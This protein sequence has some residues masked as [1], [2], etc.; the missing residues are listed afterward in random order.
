[1]DVSASHLPGEL[2]SNCMD[3]AS[4]DADGDGDLDLVLAVEYERNALLLNDGDGMFIDA[5]ERLPDAALD[6]EDVEFTDVDADGDLDLVIVSERGGANELYLNDGTGRFSDA[7]ERLPVQGTSNGLAVLDLD[8]DSSPDLLIG[9]YGAQGVMINTGEGRFT[10]GTARHWPG[11]EGQTQD[12][13]L[14]DVDGDGD[15]DVVV[16]NEGQNQ[17]FINDAG[18]LVDETGSRLPER[19]DETREIRSGDMDGDGDLDLVVANVQLD[20][21]WP[22]QDWLLLNDGSGHFSDA[23]PGRFPD[24]SRD[25]FTIQAADLDGDGDLDIIGPAS[26]FTGDSLDHRVLLNDGSGTFTV[27]REGEILPSS[28]HGKGLGFDIEVGDFDGDGRNDL[29]FCDRG[30]SSNPRGGVVMRGRPS[31]VLNRPN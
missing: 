26:L 5:S 25:H 4:G 6:S 17:L 30:S 24:G 2:P 18:R 1:M 12:L 16:G 22:R 29:F 10:D 15:L 21:E 28:V 14:A 3:A 11:A 9:N 19:E 20:Y 31:L 8:G 7:S 27:A 13:E 23:E